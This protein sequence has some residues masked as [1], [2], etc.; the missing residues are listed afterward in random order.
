MCLSDAKSGI[1]FMR[2]SNFA[3]IQH[4]VTQSTVITAEWDN[5]RLHQTRIRQNAAA[6]DTKT[7]EEKLLTFGRL[8][9]GRNLHKEIL[10]S[11][12]NT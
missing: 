3:H 5:P 6:K 10:T 4:N 12:A 11:S 1:L 2:Q 8:Q 9:V 7:K